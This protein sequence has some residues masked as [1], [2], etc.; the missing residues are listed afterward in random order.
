MEL[1]ASMV[2]DNNSAIMLGGIFNKLNEAKLKYCVLRNVEELSDIVDG[3]EID[4]LVDKVDLTECCELLLSLG[5]MQSLSAHQANSSFDGNHYFFYAID[6]ETGKQI[7]LDIVSHLGF[8]YRRQFE[9]DGLSAEI[10][11]QSVVIN[12]VSCAN[13]C[14]ALFAQLL[15][16]LLDKKGKRLSKLQ[17]L[18]AK[19]KGVNLIEFDATVKKYFPTFGG[20]RVIREIVSTN[21]FSWIAKIR[22]YLLMIVSA[23]K[24]QRGWAF[25]KRERYGLEDRV[26]RRR[27]GRKQLL[28]SVYGPD[29]VGKS[30]VCKLL[31]LTMFV[32]RTKIRL[33][34]A[35][36]PKGKLESVFHRVIKGGYS[37]LLMF[38]I[39]GL[40]LKK[41]AAQDMRDLLYLAEIRTIYFKLYLMMLKCRLK[42][43]YLQDV[44]LLDRGAVDEYVRIESPFFREKASIFMRGAS[45]NYCNSVVL[46]D[47]PKRIRLRKKERTINELNTIYEKYSKAKN[48]FK[49]EMYIG[50]ISCDECGAEQVTFKLKKEIFK[51]LCRE[52]LTT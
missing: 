29:G 17:D 3:A 45:L 16:E 28:I 18:T 33:L 46:V 31:Q 9:V 11:R 7:T 36:R 35:G 1:K 10:L 40:S 13:G 24:G 21:Q 49:D 32:P 43:P 41:I 48:E 34:Y 22:L 51:I 37:L 38:Q 4:I 44:F 39:Y 26:W 27:L 19:I 42:G 15:H 12:R 25:L 8:D 2:N 20:N 50:N 6:S 5:L 47:T 23:P 14:A 30:T 52:R